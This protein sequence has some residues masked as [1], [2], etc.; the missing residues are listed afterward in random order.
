MVALPK[1]AHLLRLRVQILSAVWM[2]VCYERCVVQ[3]EAAAAGR[4][5]VQGS[6]TDCVCV[7]QCDHVKQYRAKLTH[8]E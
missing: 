8:N 3:V 6:P 7:V 2:N 1:F 5:L 4:F